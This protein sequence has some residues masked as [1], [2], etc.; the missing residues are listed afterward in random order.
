MFR[1]ILLSP[2]SRG[3]LTVVGTR[4]GRSTLAEVEPWRGESLAHTDR[5]SHQERF[6]GLSAI[7]RCRKKNKRIGDLQLMMEKGIR[8]VRGGR[9]GSA[10]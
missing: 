8:E 4:N 3:E 5:S 2:V 9:G 6:P 10:F 1:S 7:S